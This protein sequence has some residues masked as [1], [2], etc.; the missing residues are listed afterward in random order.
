[1]YRAI[2]TSIVS[3]EP[4]KVLKVFPNKNASVETE[5]LTMLGRGNKNCVVLS[6]ESG[7]NST[8]TDHVL[9]REHACNLLLDLMGALCVLGNPIALMLKDNLPTSI[10]DIPIKYRYGH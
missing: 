2:R 8:L 4:G 3:V 10:D 1:M 7:P 5:P 9:C 6:L